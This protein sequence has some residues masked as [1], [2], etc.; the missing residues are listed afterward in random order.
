MRK[1]RE[2]TVQDDAWKEEL[3]DEERDRRA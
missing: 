1:D 2:T 3:P